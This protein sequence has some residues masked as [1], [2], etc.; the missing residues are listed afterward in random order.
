MGAATKMFA[1]KR[2]EVHS[3]AIQEFMVL[4]TAYHSASQP[5]F[6]QVKDES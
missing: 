3:D 5:E 6:E 1:K 4:N 2:T